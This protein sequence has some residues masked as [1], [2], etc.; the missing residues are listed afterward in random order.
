M[1]KLYYAYVSVVAIL[2][3]EDYLLERIDKI[4]I[5]DSYPAISEKGEPVMYYVLEAEDGVINS[6]WELKNLNKKAL[7]L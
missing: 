6:K 4:K 3:F 2:Y 7:S 5:V 1:R